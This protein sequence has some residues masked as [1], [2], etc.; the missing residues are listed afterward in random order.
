[1]NATP[2]PG[3][4]TPVQHR[5]S[6]FELLLMALFAA[7][8]V[9]ANV[10]LR[11]PI[12]VP[13]HSGLAWMTLL[14][15]ARAVVGRPGTACLVGI[16]S[17]LMATFAGVGD[18]GALDTFLSYTAAGVGVDAVTAVTGARIQPVSCALAGLGGNLLKLA[19]KTVLELWVG[20]PAGFLLL[21]RAYPAFT[22][23]AFGLAGGYLGYLVTD[24][25][26]RAGF[27]TYLAEKR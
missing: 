1:M 17:G 26:R 9:V 27:F 14:V 24:A 15:T 6:T 21:G 10:A 8:I 20:I 5:F 19:T 2:P 23:A 16:A 12:R 4:G 22:A 13:G 11:F 3:S 7:L 25:L 18:K